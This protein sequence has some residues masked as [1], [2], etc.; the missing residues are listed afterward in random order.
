LLAGGL[1]PREPIADDLAHHDIESVTIVH[2]AI[3]VT[4]G[5]FIEA[6]EQ[7]EGLDRNEAP[8]SPR[9]TKDQKFSSPLMCTS[10]RTYSTAWSTTSCCNSSS[11]SH[12]FSAS[13]KSAEPASTCSRISD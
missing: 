5:L 2:L 9:L 11:A 12:D 6:S 1:I 8:F 13:V 3:V 4:E 7:V 10:P